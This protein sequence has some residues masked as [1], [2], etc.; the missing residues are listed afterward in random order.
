MDLLDRLLHHDRWTTEQLLERCRELRA[1]Q[2]AQPF[3]VGHQTL[4]ATFQHMLGNVR[5][6]SDLM[7]ERPVW[8]SPEQPATTLDDL[9]AQWQAA[10]DDFAALARTIASQNRWDATYVDVLDDP[11]QRKTF[12][13][14]IAHVI[15]H[16]MHHRCEVIHMLTRLGLANVLEGDVLSWEQQALAL[17][18]RHKQRGTI[19]LQL[20]S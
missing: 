14:T 10:Y 1:E 2:R 11:P 20:W 17:V 9:I 12:G 13:G 6:W 8:S 18:R 15:T 5:A 7:A 3:D 4:E 16:N 19:C